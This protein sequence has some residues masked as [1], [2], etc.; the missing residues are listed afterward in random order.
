MINL[1]QKGL[2]RGEISLLVQLSTSLVQ[3]YLTIY[4]QNDTPFNRQRLQE[5]LERLTQANRTPKKGGL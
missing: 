5:Q 2:S 3:D 4:R 1:H